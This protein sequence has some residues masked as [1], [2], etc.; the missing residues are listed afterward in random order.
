M[1]TEENAS[2]MRDCSQHCEERLAACLD[3][4][5]EGTCQLKYN[6]CRFACDKR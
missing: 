4:D 3:G 2:S 5:S 6:Q 1:K